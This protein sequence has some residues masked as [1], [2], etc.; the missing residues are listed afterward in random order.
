VRRVGA[1]VIV[2][3]LAGAAAAVLLA[4][5]EDEP[6]IR[7]PAST[8]TATEAAATTA[9]AAT[10]PAPPS[11]MTVAVDEPVPTTP[12]PPAPP[13]TDGAG[14]GRMLV[15]FQDDPSFRWRDDREAMLD[16]ARAAATT[17][18]RATVHWH[19][20]APTRPHRPADAFDPAYR[21]EDIDELARNAQRRGI[22]LLLTI[23][24]TPAWA[25]GG[26][27]PNRPPLDSVELQSFARALADRYSGRHAGYPYVR[28]FSVW[29]EPNLEQFLAPQFDE[30][31]RSVA[32]A[33]YAELAQAAYTGIKAANPDALVAIG[34]TS[35]RGRDRPSL[36]RIQ[37]SHSPA[38]FARLVAEATPRVS[39]DAWAHHPYPTRPFE[40]PDQRV[41]WPAVNLTQLERFGA[42]LDLH[43]GHRE[44]PLW[45]TEYGHETLPEERLGVPRAAQ[46]AYAEQALA[47][48]RAVPRVRMFVWFVFR[49]DPGGSWESGVI[50]ANGRPKPAL[51]RFTAAATPL[52]ARN[53]VVPAPTASARVPALELAYSTP[54]G[55]RIRV[56]VGGQSS[57]V[58][59]GR[60]GRIDVRLDGLAPGTYELTATAPNGA[61]VRRRLDLVG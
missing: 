1:A 49:D 16:A 22:E 14:P 17:V 20:A 38:R 61:S 31:G 51:A 27:R 15:G 21:L 47:L 46:S 35:A 2:L 6:R 9:A 43:F 50:A 24:G 33:L 37:D 11:P 54:A 19:Q 55:A 8:S 32:P 12:V 29:N 13:R 59:L 25:N 58:P 26:E 52:D 48:A 10:A 60:D 34:E 41:R 44:I 45:L 4:R 5:G 30:Q 39:F 57:S 42:W 53:L 36:D 40:R 7:P 56:D 3:G 28:L 23:W 18:I